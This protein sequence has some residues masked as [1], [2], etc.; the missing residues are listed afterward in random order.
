MAAE[1]GN[2]QKVTV[3]D[4]AIGAPFDDEAGA[5]DA[6][7]V[8]VI[9]GDTTGLRSGR[10]QLW[11]QNSPGVPGGSNAGDEFGFA[12]G[13]GEFGNGPRWDLAIGVPG[14]DTGGADGGKA[15]VLYGFVHG[16][17]TTTSAQLWGQNSD[18]ILDQS[19][20][21]DEFG[22]ALT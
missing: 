22:S 11:S 8:N 4:L 6:G 14:E 17:L 18:G 12:L 21:G 19:E 9:Y 3:G 15:N 7:V 1:F 5:I 10:N 20:A 13:A 2:A 16:G